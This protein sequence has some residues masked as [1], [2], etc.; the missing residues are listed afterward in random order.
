M[1]FFFVQQPVEIQYSSTSLADSSAPV[2]ESL[3][4]DLNSTENIP[5]TSQDDEEVD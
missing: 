2:S 1:H 3:N 5:I 4:P